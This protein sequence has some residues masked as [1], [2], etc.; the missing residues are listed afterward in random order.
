MTCPQPPAPS[1]GHE[2]SI[3]KNSCE[4]L[5]VQAEIHLFIDPLGVSKPVDP[6]DV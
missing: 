4:R 2:I 3:D 5:L 1:T 6:L